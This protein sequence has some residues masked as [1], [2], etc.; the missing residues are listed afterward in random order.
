MGKILVANLKLGSKITEDVKIFSG[1]VVIK[2]GAIVH[3]K[4]LQLLKTW[5]VK[6]VSSAQEDAAE[7]PHKPSPATNP[8][9]API[10]KLFALANMDNDVMKH[11]KGVAR[12]LMNKRKGG[13]E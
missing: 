10:D 5:G 12:T 2:A 1:R 13:A 11:L 3:E 7:T 6:V 4:H 8:D 9:L